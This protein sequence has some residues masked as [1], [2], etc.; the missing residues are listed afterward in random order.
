MKKYR[1]SILYFGAVMSGGAFLSFLFILKTDSFRQ[2][3]LIGYFYTVLFFV[4]FFLLRKYFLPKLKIFSYRQQWLLKTF[5]YSMLVCFIYLSGLIFQ[6]LILMPMETIEEI[7]KDQI[8]RGFLVLITMPFKTDLN[9][10]IGSGGFRGMILSFFAMIVLIGAGSFIG[11]LIEFKWQENSQTRARQK[12]ELTALHA[13]MEPHFLFN[14]LNTI[15]STIKTDPD[16][17]ENLILHL[18]DMFRYIFNNSGKDVTE[19]RNEIDFTKKYIVLLKARYG[20]ILQAEWQEQV[21]DTQRLVPVFLLQP[22]IENAIRHGWIDHKTGFKIWVSLSDQNLDLC[23]TVRD[24]GRGIHPD[25]LKR[26]PLA[27]HA[28]DNISKRLALLY[29]KSKLLRI[30]SHINQG[31]ELSIL[32]PGGNR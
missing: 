12:A 3:V 13:Q 11:S 30:Q 24:N 27:G 7:I 32:V 31:T 18:S 17:A 23:I 22:L 6:I 9:E 16:Q 10:M 26:L 1:N 4:S 19:L 29:K 28:L 14:S 8:W 2:A 21:H 25:I 20:T 5:I 15:A